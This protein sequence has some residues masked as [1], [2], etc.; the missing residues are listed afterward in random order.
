[1][2]PL[3]QVSGLLLHP[4]GWKGRNKMFFHV[5]LVDNPET[6]GKREKSRQDHWKYFDEHREHFVAR[7]ATLTDDGKK[8]L[9]SVLFVE[10]EN[11]SQV[12]TF[13]KNEPHNKNGVYGKVSI[14]RWGCG[15]KR[16][17][18]DFP[19]NEG[20]LCWYIRGY[21]RPNMHE[22]RMELLS[23]HRAYFKPYDSDKFIARGPIFGND[24]EEWQGSANLISLPSRQEVQNFLAHEPYCVNDL[25]DRVV[26]ER[27]K[28]G[29]RPGQ[30]V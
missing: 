19:R 12:E 20:Q 7:G 15:L 25:Y 2:H 9:S 8:I 26:I 24:G 18:R 14:R 6:P 11:Q 17:Q 21:G 10:F 16:R 27:Y 22:K 3:R 5:Q 13:V 1:M 30:T 28:F 23:E 29:G 4:S